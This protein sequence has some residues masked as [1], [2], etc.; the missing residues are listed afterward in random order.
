MSSFNANQP[1]EIL[2]PEVGDVS[3]L[4]EYAEDIQRRLKDLANLRASSVT[5]APRG[6]SAEE[7][8]LMQVN[9]WLSSFE[10][11]SNG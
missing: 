9:Q 3:V 11:Q 6:R 8:M 10:R 2:L 4:V 1:L 5:G 7:S